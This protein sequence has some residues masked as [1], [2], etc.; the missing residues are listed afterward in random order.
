MPR[1][2][3]VTGNMNYSISGE[4]T[5]FMLTHNIDY[6]DALQG[7]V[8]Q[9][10]QDYDRAL[11]ARGKLE[12]ALANV[13]LHESEDKW[14]RD[15]IDKTM[16]AIDKSAVY[17]DYSTALTTAT[18][19]ASKALADP[20]LMGR[21]RY[22]EQWQ[23]ERDTVQGRQDINQDTKDWWLTKHPY[24]YKDTTDSNGNIIGGT[25]FRPQDQPVKDINWEEA[26]RTVFQLANPNRTATSRESSS[27]TDGTGS[28]S[29]SGRDVRQLKPQQ[30][31]E[32]LEQY[33][34][35]HL[36]EVS[37]AWEV[38]KYKY[39]QM[40]E[41]L[42]DPDIDEYTRDNLKQE[43]KQIERFL[44]KNGNKDYVKFIAHNVYDTKYAKNLGYIE[45][46]TSS[47][48]D[49]RTVT[50]DPTDPNNRSNSSNG[51]DGNG[52]DGGGRD[53]TSTEKGY[54]RRDNVPYVPDPRADADNINSLYD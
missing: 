10:R 11:E 41:K 37:Q 36:T 31:I 22:Y 45:S 35:T 30:I 54:V 48:S 38:A 47:T 17:G 13:P 23:K 26:A 49:S 5:P 3:N 52:G 40:I 25:T 53:R 34:S 42:N 51:S 50:K 4:Y 1:Q 43:I 33:V 27:Y 8:N 12:T 9:T 32:N 24:N 21:A 2:K 20:G 39:E 19:L 29:S 18:K 28:G 14:K 7:F 6:G 46:I 16:A 44:F 15:Y